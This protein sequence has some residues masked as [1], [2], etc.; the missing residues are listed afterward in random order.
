MSDAVI[1][2][3]RLSRRFG[4]LLAVDRLTFEIDRGKVCG[5]LGRMA[6]VR[7]PPFES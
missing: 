2:V 5:F 3:E 4:R 7:R 1:S 6:P